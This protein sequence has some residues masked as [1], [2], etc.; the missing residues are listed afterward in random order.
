MNILHIILITSSA[1]LTAVGRPPRKA[2]K[3]P[4]LPQG[5]RYISGEL[6]GNKSD[7]TVMTILVAAAETVSPA[8]HARASKAVVLP[9][10]TALAS[11]RARAKMRLESERLESE[12]LER[13][14]RLNRKIISDV[15]WSPEVEFQKLDAARCSALSRGN[16]KR[17][18]DII[19]E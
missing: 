10:Q 6:F 15:G 18:S 7:E 12:R 9:T 1:T 4:T 17:K 5:D 19:I 13:T 3:Q 11:R 8:P 16:L 14:S 2:F